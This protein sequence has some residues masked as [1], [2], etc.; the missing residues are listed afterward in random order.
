MQ[1]VA[2]NLDEQAINAVK[3]YFESITQNAVDAVYESVDSD[4]T[5]AEFMEAV[6][7]KVNQL[8]SELVDSKYSLTALI[9]CSSKFMFYFLRNSNP[10][11]PPLYRGG[12]DSPPVKGEAEG[13]IFHQPF[14]TS[15]SHSVSYPHPH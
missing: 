3:E 8:S 11:R 7:Q 14:P 12:V 10:S 4:T 9:A 2:M 15:N 6:N 13:V 5:F 1:G